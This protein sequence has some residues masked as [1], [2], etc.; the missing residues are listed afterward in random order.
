MGMIQP[1]AAPTP[2]LSPLRLPIQLN[3]IDLCVESVRK[4]E[5][6]GFFIPIILCNVIYF[7][8]FSVPLMKPCNTLIHF[9]GINVLQYN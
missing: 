3:L 9:R 8:V 7:F 1:F 6:G 5:S 2:P 4:V